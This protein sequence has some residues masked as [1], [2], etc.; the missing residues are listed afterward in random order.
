[1]VGFTIWPILDNYCSASVPFSGTSNL[2]IRFLWV[3]YHSS[4][5]LRSSN[6]NFSYSSSEPESFL[7]LAI[8]LLFILFTAFV[9]RAFRYS[10]SAGRFLVPWNLKLSAPSPRADKKVDL[11]YLA[12]SC[13][14]LHEFISCP[15][16][17]RR[18]TG[19]FFLFC[20]LIAY[21]AL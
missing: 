17:C 8:K 14:I 5:I 15:S 12:W 10:P 20:F 11:I 13:M 4:P 19:W 7:P 21:A 1:M 16:P 6:L 2:L 18:H 9:T 3:L